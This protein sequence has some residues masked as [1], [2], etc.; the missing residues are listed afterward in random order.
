MRKIGAGGAAKR[1]HSIVLVGDDAR[2]GIGL[3]EGLIGF[4]QHITGVKRLLRPL[5][6]VSQTAIQGMKA[7]GTIQ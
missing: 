2:R 5:G 6:S 7:A 4:S 3:G 1:N